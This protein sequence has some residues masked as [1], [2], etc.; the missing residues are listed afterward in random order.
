M[1]FFEQE[2]RRIISQNHPDATYVGRAC[3]VPLGDDL[4]AK[5]RF[6]DSRTHDHFDTLQMVILNRQE[7]KVDELRLRFGDTFGKKQVS[8][9]NFPEGIVPHI[10]V[11]RGDAEW[12]VYKPT[13]KDYKLLSDGVDEYLSVFQTQN[14]AQTEQ[15]QRENDAPGFQQTMSM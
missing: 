15:G 4:R 9:P 1:N 6:V 8:N 13:A 3:Y 7:G 12:Y 5:I 10:W 14:M 11:D 2:L